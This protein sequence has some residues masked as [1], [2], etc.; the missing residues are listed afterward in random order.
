MS[1]ELSRANS[2]WYNGFVAHPPST[3]ANWQRH[4]CDHHIRPCFDFENH[5]KHVVKLKII[6]SKEIDKK[7]L[8]VVTLKS[9]EMMM[10]VM[11]VM[12]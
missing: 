7:T 12:V 10:E 9:M 11:I 4:R 6:E 2:W 1:S 5:P 8:E 3:M